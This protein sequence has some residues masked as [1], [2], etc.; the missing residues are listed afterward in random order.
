M[1]HPELDTCLPGVALR[2]LTVPDSE[3]YHELLVANR[4]HLTRLGNYVGETSATP[5]ELRA[6]FLDPDDSNVRYGIWRNDELLGRIDLIPVAHPE[7]VIGFWLAEHATG[8]GYATA[9]CRAVIDYARD[10][11]GATDIFGGV[12]HGNIRSIALL[13]RLGFRQA[14]VFQDYARYHRSLRATEG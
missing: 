13:Q 8:H 1:S 4:A 7:Y 12:T 2:K 14:A 3:S 5:A 11:L 9:A 10:E 6:Y